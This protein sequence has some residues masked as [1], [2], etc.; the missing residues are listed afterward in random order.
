MSK[1]KNI[2]EKGMNT[3]VNPENINPEDFRRQYEIQPPT[4][5]SEEEIKIHFKNFLLSWEN[6]N[7]RTP[8]TEYLIYSLSK[9][10]LIEILEF[11]FRYNQ[12]MRQNFKEDIQRMAAPKYIVPLDNSLLEEFFKNKKD[13]K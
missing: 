9:I 2:F 1:F 5:M 8:E 12:R 3:D 11:M 7:G 10:P 6:T 4:P 13:G